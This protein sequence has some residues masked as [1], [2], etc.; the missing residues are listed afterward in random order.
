MPPKQSPDKQ[1]TDIPQHVLEQHVYSRLWPTNVATARV[2][3]LKIDRTIHPFYK[4]LG[5]V[6]EKLHAPPVAGANEK[7]KLIVRVSFPPT[8]TAPHCT[9]YITEAYVRAMFWDGY[10]AL[11]V[12]HGEELMNWYRDYIGSAQGRAAYKVFNIDQGQMLGFEFKPLRPSKR[13]T[14]EALQRGVV[15][16]LLLP[17][18][19]F[20][21]ETVFATGP[22]VQRHA[23]FGTVFTRYNLAFLR[24]AHDFRQSIQEFKAFKVLHA[25]QEAEAA[26]AAEAAQAAQ[27]AAAA[28]EAARAAR[29]VQK[30]RKNPN[31]SSLQHTFTHSQMSRMLPHPRILK[32]HFKRLRDVAQTNR[33]KHEARERRRWEQALERGFRSNSNG[34]RSS[35]SDVKV[36]EDLVHQSLKRA[37][38][39]AASAASKARKTAALAAFEDTKRKRKR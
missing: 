22:N 36:P 20:T 27:A 5:Q 10:N 1:L 26:D 39:S 2:A 30:S 11:H 8:F 15:P 9:M 24:K 31:Y 38:A 32:D 19:D 17:Y 12:Q 29:T 13:R 25:V 33:E 28:A 34:S 7:C 35:S 37:T 16:M 18:S 3:G 6:V 14:F 4:L 21:L 23:M